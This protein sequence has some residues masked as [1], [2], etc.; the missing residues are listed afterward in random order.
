M[1]KIVHSKRQNSGL[2]FE[3]LAQQV[4]S[5][6]I[7][8]NDIKAKKALYLIRKYFKPGTQLYE[9]LQLINSVIYNEVGSWRT[10]SR[11]LSEVVLASNQLDLKKLADEKFHLISEINANFDKTI[12]YNQ[13]VP[14]YRVYG[15]IYSLLE[16]HRMKVQV[17]VSQKV[18][19]EEVVIKHL[20]DN[21]EVK[22][23]NEFANKPKSEYGEI[24][25]LAF[26][27][28]MKKFNAKYKTSLTESQQEIL[29][30]YIKCSSDRKFD[31]F[32][33]KQ[34]KNIENSLYES[35][36]TVKD[37]SLVSKIYEAMMKLV[38]IEKAPKN[39]K[40]ETLMTYGQLVDELKKLTEAKS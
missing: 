21:P 23:I 39:R 40:V 33:E 27:F 20:M 12:F 4:V 2:V 1:K 32:V 35:I 5:S 37:R 11:L 17:D 24:D 16:G 10:A 34:T 9:E 19:L 26:A 6:T 25:D 8:K 14:V 22:R 29:R 18:K 36:K 15:A 13:F 3:L 38:S 28:V 31:Q 7:A 30:E